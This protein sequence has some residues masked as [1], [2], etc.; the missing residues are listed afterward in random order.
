MTTSVIRDPDGTNNLYLMVDGIHCAGCVQKIERTLADFPALDVARVNLS[1]KRLTLK[2]RDP[3]FQSDQAL[4]AVEEKG[5]RLVPY[6][7]EAL[8]TG[9]SS[10]ERRLL[11]SM[12]VA[13]FAAANVMLLS[14]SIWAGL[15]SDMGPATRG[16]FHWIS[17]LI[18]LPAIAY[19][20]Q[21]FFASAA[22]ALKA[23]SLNMDVPI[24]LA[25]ILASAMSLFETIGGGEH[26]YFD[27]AITLLFFL[28]IGRYLDLRARAKARSA[29]EQI[30]GLRAS[31]ASRV[32]EDGTLQT[33]AA[34]AIIPG[35]TLA[36][37][38]GELIPAD[39]LVTAGL[40]DID[41]SLVTGESL[42]EKAAPGKKLYA[43]M[44][45]LS[46]ALRLRVEN[47]GEDTLLAEIA[48]LMEAAEQGKSRYVRLADRAARVYAPLVHLA[49]LGTFLGW[50]LIMGLAWQEALMT[51]ISVLIIT[52]PC[53]LGLAVPA[54][55]VVATSRLLQKGIILKAADALE[56]LAGIDLVVFDKTGT[57]T[58]GR[59]R[60]ANGN[61]IPEPARRLAA[62]IAANSSHP[63]ARA[64]RAQAPDA[65]A[66]EM[67]SEFP[68]QGLEALTEGGAVRLGRREFC[69]I[70]ADQPVTGG[71]ELWLKAAD[72]PAIR[73]IFEDEIRDDAEQVIRRLQS[74]GRS[75]LLLSGD[76]QASVARVAERLGIKDARAQT[77]PKDKLAILQDYKQ[78]GRSVLM[79]GDGLNDAPALAAATASLSPATAADIAQ[80]AADAVF[81][82]DKLG[83]VLDLL[84][85]AD[86]ARRLVTQNFAL[87]ALYN[88]IAIPIAV[89]GFV[90]PL[91][92]AIAMSASSLIVIGNALR[93]RWRP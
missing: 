3:G 49:G 29:A 88:A 41:T 31:A 7:P 66:L 15:F 22:T 78:Q 72:K 82:G 91:I 93:L 2:W 76:R 23:R 92:A 28:L 54:V 30:I 8:E 43:G 61:R 38:P 57:L 56:R 70:A 51:G 46:G 20:G 36:V 14:V 90:T 79:V 58:K 65:P 1:T 86:Q 4:A 68:G 5:F 37:A 48:R 25:V 60:L 39:G 85:I 63:L 33:I 67:V 42:P 6:D 73:F 59:L 16:L 81:Q 64:V 74:Q 18:A 47:T 24:S 75:I 32:R 53:A 21:P 19:A 26:A 83:P 12:A 84:H 62:S 69:G 52:C 34:A 55:Q 40:S 71:P 45:N 87:A 35:M 10:Q 11:K 77:A 17:A 89:L 9:K 27:A 13:G 44:L 50:W 80:V